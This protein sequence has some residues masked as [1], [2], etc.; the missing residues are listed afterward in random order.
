M[1]PL[2]E[3]AEVMERHRIK[4]VPVLSDGKLVGIVS[5]A[6]LVRA[7]ASAAQG[8]SSTFSQSDQDI[9]ESIVREL[10]GRRWALPAENVIVNDGIVH[11]WGFIGSEEEGRAMC[12][13]AENVPGVKSVE[14]HLDFPAVIPPI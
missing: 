1:T 8:S 12:V 3:I 5:R 11:L 2:Q 14:S 10:S 7:L 6:N 13:A 9:R 4:R